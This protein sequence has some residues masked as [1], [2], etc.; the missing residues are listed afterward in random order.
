MGRENK[1]FREARRR[2][3]EGRGYGRHIWTGGGSRLCSRCGLLNCSLHAEQL[4]VQTQ[5]L[6]FRKA[7]A[8]RSLSIEGFFLVVLAYVT[9]FGLQVGLLY[10]ARV[11][12]YQCRH[13]E[14]SENRDRRCSG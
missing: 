14:F 3:P 11:C 7:S 6:F 12:V 5:V 1:L 9:A 10:R 13:Q 8:T 2:I 4:C